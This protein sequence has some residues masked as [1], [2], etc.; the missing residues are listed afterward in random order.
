MKYYGF[1]AIKNGKE[2]FVEWF[3][4]EGVRDNVVSNLEEGFKIENKGERKEFLWGIN[5][6]C[7]PIIDEEGLSFEKIETNNKIYLYSERIGNEY[8]V[9][10][11]E[12]LMKNV[13]R[14]VNSFINKYKYTQICVYNNLDDETVDIDQRFDSWAYSDFYVTYLNTEYGYNFVRTIPIGVEYHMEEDTV[15]KISRAKYYID[16][17]KGVILCFS[18]CSK[19]HLRLY[20]LHKEIVNKVIKFCIDYNIENI[21]EFQITADGL[22]ESIKEGYWTPYTDSSLSLMNDKGKQVKFSI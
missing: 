16:N 12:H 8:Y 14:E 10:C 4:N 11:K 22:K 5:K 21:D 15:D 7:Y 18:R 1:K 2:I 20:S 9:E 13:G 6:F 17:D 3:W 19:K